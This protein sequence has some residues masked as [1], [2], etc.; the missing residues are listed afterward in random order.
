MR[1]IKELKATA[2]EIVQ[3]LMDKD[4][5]IEEA[6]IVS[7]M[8]WIAVFEKGMVAAVENAVYKVSNPKEEVHERVPEVAGETQDRDREPE[9]ELPT[10]D[11]IGLDGS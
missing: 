3:K 1:E 2:N 4:F 5:T 7:D 11:D 8:I 10:Q 9:E 6:V